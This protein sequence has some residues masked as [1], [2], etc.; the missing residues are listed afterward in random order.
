M[1]WKDLIK[2]P[3][4]TLLEIRWQD[5][6]CNQNAPYWVISSKHSGTYT[7]AKSI[8]SDSSPAMLAA[9]TSSSGYNRGCISPSPEGF[10]RRLLQS[11]QTQLTVLPRRQPDLRPEAR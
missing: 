9:R 8:A 1:L 10:P 2:A 3:E 4:L 6:V 11:S 7:E 5:Q